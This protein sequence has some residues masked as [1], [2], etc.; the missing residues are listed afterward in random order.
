MFCNQC[1]QENADSSQFCG[2]CGQPLGAGAANAGAGS[3]PTSSGMPN[4]DA[5]TDGKAVV[6]LILGILSLTFFSILAGIP[7]V[8][9]GHI[10]RSNIKKSMGRLKGEGMALAGLIMGYISF[11]AI[12]FI[13][14]IMA[15]AIPNLL[16]ARLAANESAAVGA[17]RTINTAAVT[18]QAMDQKHGYPTDLQRMGPGG[19]TPGGNLITGDLAGGMKSG[20]SFTYTAT[21]TDGDQVLDAYFVTAKPYNPGSTGVRSFCSDQ[22]GVIHVA[23]RNETCT[24]ESPPI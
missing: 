16:R 13:L 10:S 6:S 18:Y 5:Q 15:I 17:I 12:P 24:L 23:Y 3:A 22:S 9:V 21:D 7:A 1:G 20:Y 8:V 19:A 14:I 2:K 11:L 4:A